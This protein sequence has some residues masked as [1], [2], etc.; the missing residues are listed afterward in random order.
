MVLTV[1][2]PTIM[3]PTIMFPFL[4]I[5]LHWC[6]IV[7][8]STM[9]P[10]PFPLYLYIWS[11]PPCNWAAFLSEA[12]EFLLFYIFLNEKTWIYDSV[13]ISSA[14]N[15]LNCQPEW[16]IHP[17]KNL[18][19]GIWKCAVIYS[20][21]FWVP[22]IGI[23]DKGDYRKN[24]GCRNKQWGATD[25]PCKVYD[26]RKPSRWWV[27]KGQETLLTFIHLPSK[28]KGQNT[29]IKRLKWGQR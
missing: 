9:I 13:S 20:T 2:D 21:S 29:K 18:K 12:P 6:P 23:R 7:I 19:I 22:G 1:Y 27:K 14:Y 17:Y 11:I 3:Y 28:N 25:R 8:L 15:K 26:K 10:D 16:N 24:N 4:T 5:V